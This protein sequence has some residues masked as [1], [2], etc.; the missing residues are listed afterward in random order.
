M[1][2]I[3]TAEDQKPI[4]VSERL[5]NGGLV[6]AYVKHTKT[7]KKSH[8]GDYN[9]TYGYRWKTKWFKKTAGKQYAQS[10]I[11]HWLPYVPLNLPIP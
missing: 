10:S 9:D 6:W 2:Q 7:W 4:P 11:S 1:S 8:F 3:K 5:P